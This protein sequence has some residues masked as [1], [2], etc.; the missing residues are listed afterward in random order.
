MAVAERLRDELRPADTAARLG[1]DEFVIVCADPG[2]ANG[3][4]ALA[5]RIEDAIK[6]P[7]EVNGQW[8]SVTASIGITVGGGVDAYAEALLRDADAAMYGAKQ[9]GKARAELA[10]TASSTLTG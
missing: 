2:G 1:G 4:L 6:R 9:R 10:P 3:A 7:V 5:E 8:V